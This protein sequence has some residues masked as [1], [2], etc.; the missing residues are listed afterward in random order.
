MGGIEF[1]GARVGNILK[2]WSEPCHFVGMIP[3][4]EAAIR[5]MD[6]LRTRGGYD[7]QGIVE[8]IGHMLSFVPSRSSDPY[9]MGLSTVPHGTTMR[10]CAATEAARRRP[11]ALRPHPAG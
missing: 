2:L 3:A 9:G 10:G 11:V 8:R 6:G 5:G 4:D 7:L 1:F